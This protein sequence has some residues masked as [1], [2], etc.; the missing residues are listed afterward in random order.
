MA[1]RFKMHVK[2]HRHNIC[3]INFVGA[4]APSACTQA[5]ACWPTRRRA[6][7]AH[8][9]AS[10]GGAETRHQLSRGVRP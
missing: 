3:L 6:D 7:R 8:H 2:D 9:P 10:G 5:N 1:Q 4:L